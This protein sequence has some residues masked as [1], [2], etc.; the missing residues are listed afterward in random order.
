[1][2][3]QSDGTGWMGFYA[4]TMAAIA[5][6]LN[7]RGRPA[8]DLVLKFLEHFALI[9][10]AL[11][12]QDLWDEADGFFYDRLR[13]ADGRSI[14][15]EVRSIVGI[16]P[17]LGV[18]AI[19][20]DVVDRAETVNKRAAEM[21]TGG[22]SGPRRPGRPPHAPRRRRRRA[23]SSGCSQRALR[24]VGV[25]LAV[26]AARRLALARRPSVRA[27]RRRHVVADRLRAGRV[28]HRHVRRQLE[29]ARAGLDAGQ[30]P[31]RRGARPLCALLR[32]RPEGRVSDRARGRS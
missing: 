8:T 16:L 3:E 28:D 12:S 4:L 13:L 22:A 5:S 32:R 29:L 2:L 10:D 6:I 7:N 26:R 30:L 9:S 24:R 14:A 11:E 19:D 21:L 25:P 31:R 18:A 15:I 23:A 1:M 27:R 20:E 17:L